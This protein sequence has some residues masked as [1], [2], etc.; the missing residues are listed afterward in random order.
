ML[1]KSQITGLLGDVAPFI[2]VIGPAYGAYKAGSAALAGDYRKA[3]EEAANIIPV[4]RIVGRGI[5]ALSGGR[6]SAEIGGVLNVARPKTEAE[7]RMEVARRNAALPVD[8]GGLGLPKNNTPMDRARAMG[9]DINDPQ[10][11]GTLADILAFDMSM[12]GKNTGARTTALGT[13]T[14][15]NPIL[16]SKFAGMQ[17]GSNVM[18]L[19]VRKSNNGK[20][21]IELARSGV[22]AQKDPFDSMQDAITKSS[23]KESWDQVTQDDVRNWA[24]M[25]SKNFGSIGLLKTAM[26]GAGTAR[27]LKDPYHDF[28]IFQDP[29]QLRSRFAAFDPMRRN[30]ADLLAFNGG[31]RGLLNMPNF[32][33]L[34]SLLG[35]QQ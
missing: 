13:F 25:V 28:R 24:D 2:P 11:H 31:G 8:Q 15:D 22:Y 14:T 9:F 32:E 30:E 29:S 3:A 10:Y 20:E 35:E 34:Y 23:G 7:A 12:L 27:T 19:L 17:E 26:D 21:P 6:G 18:P 33:Q 5:K 4:G 1:T 16:A